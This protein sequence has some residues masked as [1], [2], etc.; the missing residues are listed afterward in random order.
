MFLRALLPDGWMP[1]GAATPFT[2]CSVDIDHHDGKAPAER[3]HRHAPC[4]FAAAAQLAP[5]AIATFAFWV[6]TEA[7]RVASPFAKDRVEPAPFY[8][9]NA[10]RAPP[11]LA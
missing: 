4:A 6:S 7:W 5:P 2:I 8:R 11:A 10:A 9:P 3:D 1:S